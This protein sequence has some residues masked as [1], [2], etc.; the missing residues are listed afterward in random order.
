M[1]KHFRYSFRCLVQFSDDVAFSSLHR[2]RVAWK[3]VLLFGVAKVS[4]G[5]TSTKVVCGSPLKF[6]TNVFATLCVS[7][8]VYA[9]GTRDQQFSRVTIDNGRGW[10][11]E[12]RCDAP[13]CFPSSDYLVSNDVQ[14]RVE[15]LNY[16]STY[17]KNGI[18]LIRVMFSDRDAENTEF[19]PSLS[20]IQLASQ[21]MMNVKG[22]SCA[23]SRVLD[24]LFLLSVPPVIGYQPITRDQYC[25]LLFIDAPPPRLEEIF[26]LHLNGVRRKGQLIQVPRIVFRAGRGQRS[27]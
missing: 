12:E 24:R 11:V 1:G 14:I 3:P 22:L 16:H 21:P 6:Y 27:W 8:L 7:I 17:I 13:G 2:F 19:H 4:I 9:C 20:I 26:S 5:I 25:F 23:Q 15:A 18:F 10:S